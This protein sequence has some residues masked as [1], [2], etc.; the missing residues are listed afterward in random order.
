MKT[1]IVSTPKIKVLDA[2]GS[3]IETSANFQVAV[4]EPAKSLFVADNYEQ[5]VRQLCSSSLREIVQTLPYADINTMSYERTSIDGPADGVAL[6]RLVF[7]SGSPKDH[8]RANV[9]LSELLVNLADIGVSLNGF[10][11]DNLSYASEIAA[12]MLQ[13]QQAQAL[14]EAKETLASGVLGIV[15]DISKNVSADMSKEGRETLIRNLLVTMMS[16]EAPRTVVPV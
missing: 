2:T 5:N 1:E 14:V 4:R 11:I 3:P 6:G 9:K 8:A 7:A 16:N 15:K 13:K 12:A 10:G